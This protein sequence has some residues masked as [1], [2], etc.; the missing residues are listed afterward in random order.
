MRVR[1]YIHT[2][3]LNKLLIFCLVC[4]LQLGTDSIIV[5]MSL[6][7]LLWQSFV[8]EYTPILLHLYAFIE[9]DKMNVCQS[10]FPLGA[11]FSVF[12]GLLS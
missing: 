9:R 7:Q 12:W 6:F 1:V 5:V 11:I 10:S 4:I 2:Y 3:V 8:H